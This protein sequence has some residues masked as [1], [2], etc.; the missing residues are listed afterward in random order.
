MTASGEKAMGTFEPSAALAVYEDWFAKYA[1]NV[2]DEQ[3]LDRKHGVL[4]MTQKNCR[5]LA[6]EDPIGLAAYTRESHNQQPYVDDNGHARNEGDVEFG[7]FSPYGIS[8][9]SIVP[10][11]Q[12]ILNL[13]VPVCLS[14]THIAFGSIRMEPVFMV[15]GQSATTAAAIAIENQT[16][17]QMVD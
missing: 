15:L 12:E 7:G 14:A 17:V 6:A 2:V 11:Q 16:N 5:G 13:L 9:R 10:K 3:R 8:Y 4:M 1:F